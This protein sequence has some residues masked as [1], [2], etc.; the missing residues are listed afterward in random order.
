MY[1]TGWLSTYLSGYLQ[2]N[3]CIGNV[4]MTERPTRRKEFE[5]PEEFLAHL[6]SLK[7]GTS[8]TKIQALCERVK[9]LVTELDIS[10]ECIGFIIDGDLAIYWKD[11]FSGERSRGTKSVSH[12]RVIPRAVLDATCRMHLNLCLGDSQTWQEQSRTT[13]ILL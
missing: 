11:Y 6:H 1:P 8:V 2:R 7:D 3:I 13:C 9:L 4:L 12:S 5:I 10:D